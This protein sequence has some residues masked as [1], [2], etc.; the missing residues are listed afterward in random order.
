MTST[1]RR[2]RTCTMAAA[3]AL[4]AGVASP[5]SAD[6][7]PAHDHQDHT[8]A[9]PSQDGV[10]G[11]AGMSRDVMARI[12]ALDERIKTL[13]TDMHMFTG[14]L[15]IETMAA[16]LTAMVERQSLMWDQM[17]RMPAEMM[18]RMMQRTIPEAPADE[19][20]GGMC[21]PSP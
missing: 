10:A 4:Y 3:I 13:A 6:T 11:I 17:G 8:A 20:P 12:A 1:L 19:E 7:P 9:A 2:L 21:A 18:G 14:E 5:Q 16:L 15:K